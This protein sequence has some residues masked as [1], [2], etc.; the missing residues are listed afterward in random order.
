MFII[1]RNSY[2]GNGENSEEWNV[3]KFDNVSSNIFIA[4]LLG[5][6]SLW[7]FAELREMDIAFLLL[8]WA[9]RALFFRGT[10]SDF[11]FLRLTV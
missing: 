6:R 3:T 10:E 4:Q 5:G 7:D 11:D 9:S 1:I 8:S 2:E